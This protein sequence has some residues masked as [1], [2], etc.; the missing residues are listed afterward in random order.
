MSRA[1]FRGENHLKMDG[2]GRVSIPAEFRR[3]LEGNDPDWSS[4]TN[5]RMHVHYGSHLKGGLE[6]F[7][8]DGQNELE[9]LVE[10]MPLGSVQRK[11]ATDCYMTKTLEV[12]LDDTGR[13]VLPQ[14]LRDKMALGDGMQI[15]ARGMGAS[16]EMWNPNVYNDIH[17]DDVADF[18]ASQAPDFDPKSLLNPSK[19]QLD[20]HRQRDPRD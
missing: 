9:A 8:V 12:R 3:V 17:G 10:A 5:P 13:A 18:L 4:E 19:V 1:R 15:L 20:D 7:T 6:V 2:K 14:M 16:F 11:V